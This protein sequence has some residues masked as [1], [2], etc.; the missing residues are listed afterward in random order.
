LKLAAN[1]VRHT[2]LL[3]LFCLCHFAQFLPFVVMFLTFLC[4][5]V[6]T[7]L[8][9]DLFVTMHTSLICVWLFLLLSSLRLSDFSTQPHLKKIFNCFVSFIWHKISYTFFS[10]CNASKHSIYVVLIPIYRFGYERDK[11]WFQSVTRSMFMDLLRFSSDVVRLSL[12][13]SKHLFEVIKWTSS[14]FFSCEKNS[15]KPVSYS[16]RKL[17]IFLKVFCDKPGKWTTRVVQWFLQEQLRNK[18]ECC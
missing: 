18:T 2:V 12:S 7:P 6:Q 8:T 3:V 4:F 5:T 16:V 17:V 11:L 10:F 13:N 9:G 15:L 14:E 1:A